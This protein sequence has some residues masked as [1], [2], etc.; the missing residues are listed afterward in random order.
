MAKQVEDAQEQVFI[1]SGILVFA[2]KVIDNEDSKEMREWIMMTKVSKL[3]EEEKIEYGRKVAAEV[4]EKAA[5][6]TK[7]AVEKATRENEIGI[8][9]RMLSNG[10]SLEQVK[11]VV[12][13]LTEE[14][15]KDLQKEV[16]RQNNND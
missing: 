6:A 9:K 14:E 10:I 11:A 3:F 12:T 5:K 15:V 7:E 13:I 16:K 2:D 1:L 8:V 4:S